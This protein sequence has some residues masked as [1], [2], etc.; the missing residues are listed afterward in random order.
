MSPE[1]AE[2]VFEPFYT[3]KEVGRGSGLGLS[4]VYGFAKQSG[5]HVTLDSEQ[6]HGTTVTLYLPRSAG[7]TTGA[8]EIAG[9]ELPLGDGQTVLV[10]EDD[11]DVRQLAVDLLERLRYR[12][13]DV[14][15]AA[16]GRKVL[17]NGEAVDLMLSDVV[18]PG[19]TSGPT[20]AQE[21][22]ARFPAVSIVLMSGYTADS[23]LPDDFTRSDWVVLN[24]PF[25]TAQL[26]EAMRMALD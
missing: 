5:G 19:G 1:V 24:K 16:S 12:V 26:A 9:D 7:A 18:L 3:T 22:R 13:I 8:A 25:K 10:I 11:D 2:H 20:F 6:G 4:M 17:D 23:A 15:D 14:A 21:V